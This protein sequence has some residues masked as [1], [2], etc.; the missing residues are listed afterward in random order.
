M[1][2][3][4]LSLFPEAFSS[5]LSSSI[6]ARAQ[7]KGL[8]TVDCL[9][10]RDFAYNKHKRVDDKPYGGGPGM[11]LMAE[12]VA[13]AIRAVRRPGSQSRVVA[14]SPQGTPLTAHKCHQL[15]AD[16]AHLVFVCG[17][18]EGIDQRVID[19]DIDEEISIGDYVLTSGCLPA[20]VLLDA[21]IRFI[22]GV[23]GDEQSAY[24]DSFSD[25]V[26]LLKGPQ[27]TKP[28]VFEGKAVPAILRSGNHQEIERWRQQ[29]GRT[30]TEQRRPDLLKNN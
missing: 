3:D 13:Q 26:C 4:I 21:L 30:R 27:Y 6:V 17:H 23:L 19:S 24:Q 18:Y 25:E 29:Q 9:N 2:V 7:K 12:P 22:P 28:E 11:L 20:Q 14:L 1:R 10:I 5:Y 16:Y 15:A 8:L